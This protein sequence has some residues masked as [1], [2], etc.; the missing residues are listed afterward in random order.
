M[1]RAKYFKVD[2]ETANAIAEYIVA[3]CEYYFYE[4]IYRHDEDDPEELRLK[5]RHLLEF[6][7]DLR[8]SY[9]YAGEEFREKVG[10][11]VFD[12]FTDDVPEGKYV[13]H[14]LRQ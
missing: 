10:D 4:L 9:L 6:A 7:E 14:I 8:G 1:S 2:K 5:I 3:S 11:E 13:I 12:R